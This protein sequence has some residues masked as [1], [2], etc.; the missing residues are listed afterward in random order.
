[1]RLKTV[2]WNGTVDVITLKLD[3]HYWPSYELRRGP[4]GWERTPVS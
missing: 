3:L 4:S 2:M 1:M